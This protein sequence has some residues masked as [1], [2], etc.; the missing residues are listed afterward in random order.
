[1]DH[2]HWFGGLGGPAGMI[3]GGQWLWSNNMEELVAW[4]WDRS[5]DCR[6]VNQQ[7]RAQEKQ[8]RGWCPDRIWMSNDFNTQ[9]LVQLFSPTV[10]RCSFTSSR[11]N[12][13][14]WLLRWGCFWDQT[15]AEAVLLPVEHACS[16]QHLQMD[17]CGF[18]FFYAGMSKIDLL[19]IA[20]W[21]AFFGRYHLGLTL[22]QLLNR[23]WQHPRCWPCHGGFTM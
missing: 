8:S 12:L 17:I 23:L 18:G 19:S 14:D 13:L 3:E 16:N 9:S 5:W 6:C 20:Q 15:Q 11:P 4:T 2:W 10:I 1:M 22:K 21:T 7:P